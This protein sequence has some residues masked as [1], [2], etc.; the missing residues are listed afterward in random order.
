MYSIGQ[1]SQRTGVKVPT[2]RYYES[3]GLLAKPERTA[4]NQRRYRAAD[5]ERLRFIRHARDLGFA[6][7]DLSSLMELQDHPDRSCAEATEIARA[8]LVAVRAKIRRLAALEAELSRIAESCDGAGL[9][10]DCRVL[11]SLADH[12]LCQSE[13][14][15]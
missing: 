8:Q 14:R 6:I 4:G 12:G 9:S 1:M 11:A 15:G 3:V 10:G 2:I 7:A 5:L 13:H